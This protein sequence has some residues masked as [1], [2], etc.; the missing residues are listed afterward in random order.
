MNVEDLREF[1]LS[2]PV[3]EENQPWAQSRYEMLIMAS[4]V[5]V[6][7]S[8]RFGLLFG[9]LSPNRHILYQKILPTK[10]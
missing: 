1:V 7:V 2:L 8:R 4:I 3:V 9:L 10:K 5:G 6:V